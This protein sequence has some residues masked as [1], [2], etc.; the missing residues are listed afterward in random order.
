[1]L[2]QATSDAE[3]IATSM[4]KPET[5]RDLLQLF[6]ARGVLATTAIEGNTLNEEEALKAVQGTLELPESQQYLGQ[7]I[8]NILEAANEIKDELV[9]EDASPRLTRAKVEHYNDMVLKDLP[10]D[11]EV[12]PGR[13]RTHSV[14]VARY[15]GA[16]AQDCEYLLDRL[17]EWLNDSVLNS[18]EPANRVPFAIL[19]AI[20]AHLYVAWIHPFGD[21]NGRTARLIEVQILIAAE[22]PAP[23]CHLLSNHYNLT[24]TEYY[25]QLDLAGRTGDP[26]PFVEYAVRGLVDGLDDALEKIRAQQF[27][28][29]WE[30]YVYETFGELKTEA[31][32][33]RLRLVLDLSSRY[34]ET[35][36]P[37]SKQDLRRLS[38]ALSE[39]YARKTVKTLTRDLNAVLSM[40]LLEGEDGGYVPRD[41]VILTFRPQRR[42]ASA[43][44]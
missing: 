29:R 25:R 28:D 24:R 7:E 16:P 39:A 1:M 23:A 33:R 38:P 32:R 12:V 22:L 43:P 6:L 34:Q 13:V 9:A 10:L 11:D 17:S 26:I 27:R 8:E 44:T 36:E 35:A 19:K 30:Q 3:H 20:I 37:T 40:G 42:N 5:G 41:W 18:D 2:G 15:R 14:G 31:D 21:G 4:L